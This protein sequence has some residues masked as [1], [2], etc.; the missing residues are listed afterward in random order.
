MVRY[1]CRRIETDDENYCFVLINSEH[2]HYDLFA[3]DIDQSYMAR[4]ESE[5]NCRVNV[6]C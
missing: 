5:P 1:F 6:E 4:R 2:C 3:G